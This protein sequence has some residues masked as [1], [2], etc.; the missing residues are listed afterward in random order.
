MPHTPDRSAALRTGVWTRRSGARHLVWV[1]LLAAA[2]LG[3]G[4]EDRQPDTVT[5]RNVTLDLPDDWFLVE[6]GE[7]H[8][9]I[10]N[11]DLRVPE[12]GDGP[13]PRPEGDVVAMYFTFEPETLPD[14]W[15]AFVEEQG[16]TLESDDSIVVGGNVPATR[17][18]YSYTTNG[19]PTREMVVLIPSRGIVVLAQ[20][21]PRPGG[22][23][24]PQVF[25]EYVETF[26]DVL[27]TA[28]YGAPM[29]E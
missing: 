4:E 2:L 8:L 12:E 6:R 26:L 22:E 10:A 19:V 28:E 24:A 13:R 18:V 9:S 5:W 25:L 7:T 14:D 20:P 1:L 23:D 17:I 16:A 29:M 21:I 27:Q 3:C 15:R 11:Q